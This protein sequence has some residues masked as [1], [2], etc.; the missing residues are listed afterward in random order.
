MRNQVDECPRQRL[1]VAG[2]QLLVAVEDV[3]LQL[4]DRADRPTRPQDHVA[5]VDVGRE[6]CVG[7]DRRELEIGQFERGAQAGDSA[8]ASPLST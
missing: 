2:A 6:D 7:V 3:R 1:D 4:I 8:R 5:L